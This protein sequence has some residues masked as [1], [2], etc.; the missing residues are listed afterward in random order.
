[1]IHGG[2]LSFVSHFVL[3]KSLCGVY[4]SDRSVHNAR[5]MGYE[6]GSEG[7]ERLDG[8]LSRIGAH[9]RRREQRESFA[10]YAFGILGEGARKSVEPIAA[11][12]AADPDETQRI[13]DHLLH[14][15]RD[16]P[17]SDHDVRREAARY[18]MDAMSAQDPLSVWI[19]DDTG[20]LKQ[21]THSVGVQR[22]YT[23]S[24]GKIANCQ[25][26]V[27][28]CVANRTAHVPIDVE[29]YLPR[30]WIDDAPRRAA[31]RIPPDREFQT[32]PELALGM[33]A[34]AVQDG[35]PGDIVLAD[36]AYGTTAYFRRG[37][38]ENG[39]DF[40]VAVTATTRVWLLDARDRCQGEPI[41]AQQLGIELGPR[42]FRKWTWREGTR[43]KLASRFVFR[44]VKV[45]H[46]EGEEPDDRE[47]QWLIIEWPEGEAKPTKFV[48]TTLPRRMSKKQI[49]RILK[50]RWRTEQA[51]EELKG[52]LGLDHYEGRSFP[53]WHHHVSVVLC[54]YAFVIAER[55]RHFPPSRQRQARHRALNVAA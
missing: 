52:E 39:L 47:A 29:L 18:V 35:L 6:L 7:K 23:G 21:G 37:V 44:R 10:T 30:C 16:S 33:I 17:W 13:H 9:L 4:I 26:G 1:M 46:D 41:G 11:R 27:S 5:C 45:A 32:K 43:G 15:V 22:Q 3:H 34:R 20:F 40:A 28:L 50:E 24:A 49:I 8:F 31:A 12:A 36:A 2:H 53:G 55:M 51:Y 54:C 25:I 48:L 42:A 19:V 38:R 14:F